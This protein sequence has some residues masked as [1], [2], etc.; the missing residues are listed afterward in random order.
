MSLSIHPK[1]GVK[2]KTIRKHGMWISA[3]VIATEMIFSVFLYISLAE[4]TF[5]VLPAAASYGV[6]ESIA[7]Q[8]LLT[9]TSGNPLGGSGSV[10]CFRYSI[11]DSVSS[12]TQLWPGGTPGNSTT[13]VTDGIFSDQLGRI[14]SLSSLDFESTSTYFLQVQVSTSSLTCATGLETLSP[15]QQI[16]SDAWSQTSQSVFGSQ[17]QAGGPVGNTVQIGDPAI[18]HSSSTI[19]LLSLSTDNSGDETIGGSCSTNG[20]LWYDSTLKRVLVCEQSAILP[21]S[22]GSTTLGGIAIN[23]TT[24]FIQAGSA[25]LSAGANITLGQSG[26]TIT[27]QGAGGTVS[28][29]EWPP[30]GGQSQTTAAMAANGAITFVPFT[31]G[32]AVTAT[33]AYA[34]ISYG[35]A[36]STASTASQS[37]SIG[38]GIY[39]LGGGTST[40]NLGSVTT[41]STLYAFT[42]SSNLS[43]ASLTG[44]RRISI[45]ITIN[46]TPG[47]Y[48]YGLWVRTTTANALSMSVSMMAGYPLQVAYSGNFSSATATSEQYLPGLG[49][50]A[51]GTAALPLA[52]SIS[53]LTLAG[54][55]VDSKEPYVIFSNY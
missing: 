44:I 33:K 38:I 7:Y 8:G 12:G 55:A 41:G 32:Q 1:N 10:Y 13:T 37:I 39:T 29:F 46:A 42:Y 16:T 27:I 54:T 28:Q 23:G 35:Q 43:T 31:V 47:N 2:L 9:D 40:G 15:R 52:M 6:P 45:P 36:T 20:T 25:V 50:Y 17:L 5:V 53:S 4:R 34:F 11:W 3:A 19:T 24:T 48:W 22:N 49:V 51:A 14:D 18:G 30:G 21:I 26:S